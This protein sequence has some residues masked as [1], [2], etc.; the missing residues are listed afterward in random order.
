M[1]HNGRGT[2]GLR[3]AGVGG[4]RLGEVDGDGDGFVHR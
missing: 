3:R 4:Q 2:A 1:R